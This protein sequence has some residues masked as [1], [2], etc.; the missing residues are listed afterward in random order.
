MLGANFLVQ[1]PRMRANLIYTT[2]A[3]ALAG[4]AIAQPPDPTDNAGCKAER[5]AI[6]RDMQLAQSKGQMLRRRQLAE[7]LAE[8]QSRCETLAPEQKRAG[9]IQRLEREIRELR[10]EL[11]RSEEQLRQLKDGSS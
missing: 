5:A 1:Y 2:V 10:R 8:A 7:A 11:D 4:P 9:D 6:E 3:L